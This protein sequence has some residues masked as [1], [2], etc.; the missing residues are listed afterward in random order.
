MSPSTIALKSSASCLELVARARDGRR[1]VLPSLTAPAASEIA[2]DARQAR[3]RREAERQGRGRH[4]DE[5]STA[6]VELELAPD[7][8]AK[9]G[10][11]PRRGELDV[12][13]G[14]W[15]FSGG[16]S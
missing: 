6:E 2:R 14:R 10:D 12:M 5:R 13:P 1:D 8:V 11:I 7:L 15:S 3:A 9:L 16:T 4:G